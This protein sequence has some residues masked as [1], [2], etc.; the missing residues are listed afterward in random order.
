MPPARKSNRLSRK[1][2]QQL[3]EYGQLDPLGMTGADNDLDELISNA[4]ARSTRGR[5]AGI[6]PKEAS[7]R[8]EGRRGH[9]RD[10][11]N[12]H[13]RS[14][15]GARRGDKVFTMSKAKT[16]RPDAYT[17]LLK[18]LSSSTTTAGKTSASAS[19]GI[20]SDD[21][22]Q[23]DDANMDSDS[24]DENGIDDAL[25]NAESEDEDGDEDM[26]S[27]SEGA[28][29]KGSDAESEQ[30]DDA[31]EVD[32][33]DYSDID[34]EEADNEDIDNTE[35][36]KAED[37]MLRHFADDESAL[38]NQKLAAATQKDYKQSIINDPVLGSA[39]V[40]DIAGIGL[41]PANP[42]TLKEK[43]ANSFNKLNNGSDLSDFQRGLFNWFDQYRDVI[44]ANRSFDK[45]DEITSAYTLHA[46]NHIKKSREIESRNNS[47][48]SK[49][50]ASG[51][52]VGELRDRGFTRPRVL[53]ITPFR[54]TAFKIIKKILALASAEHK[55][56]LGRLEREYGPKEDEMSEADFFKR[57]PEDFQKTFDGNI[58]DSFRIG[59]QFYPSSVRLYAEFYR[60]DIIVASP[61][62]L[63]MT[64]GAESG[65][66]KDYD[67]LSSIEVVIVDQCDV[68]LMQNWEH[69]VHMFAHLNLTP[70]KD[71]G[72]D[73]SRVRN[74][75]LEGTTQYRRQTIM[76]SEYMT[77]EIQAI[78][79][80]HCRSIEGKV[81]FKQIYPGAIAS[82]IAK[83]PQVF[84]RVLAKRLQ[85]AADDRYAHFIENVLTNLQQETAK[86][87]RVLL[88]V[89]SYFDYVRIRNYCRDKSYSFAAISE[90]STRSEAMQARMALFK[91][92][93][94]FIIYSERAH[95]YHRYAI[96][97]VRHMVFYSLPEH[98]QFYTELVNY[99]LTSNSSADPDTKLTCTVLFNKYDQL[100]I[101][102]IVGTQM[103][104]QL[105]TSEK[106]QFTF[107]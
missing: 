60:A 32:A 12:R 78:F 31:Q 93:I 67:F 43:L 90:Y 24:G 99:M 77:P 5:I 29:S 57:K 13:D 66:R 17:N 50:H 96:K 70:K 86:D 69:V 100:K 103:A 42:T 71:H 84:K 85:T 6:I 38:M 95:F 89:P 36:S 8:P 72:C 61:I 25:L 94:Q 88:F 16:T 11:G 26:A 37:F 68:M 104:S 47:K 97:G 80:N 20:V 64:T 102:R 48:L 65:D 18:S 33:V 27:V 73:F 91:G 15:D 30:E 59:L 22:D 40:Y 51:A 7:G 55:M 101:E 106:S 3:K 35:E 63:R 75:C 44:F 83:V 41:Q 39:V 49:A 2:M 79:N 107:N 46:M 52:E 58:D 45:E 81:R 28:S 105:L 53:I 76:I 92:K 98:P 21:E 62:G 14:R 87:K 56:N 34:D 10:R 54:S 19:A 1:D 23:E 9:G 82:V 4:M 74:W